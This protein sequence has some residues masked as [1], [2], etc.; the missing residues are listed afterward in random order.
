VDLTA[1]MDINGLDIP[2]RS[3][4]LGGRFSLWCLPPLF[5]TIF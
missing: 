3:I 4:T 5:A 1:Y 2:R